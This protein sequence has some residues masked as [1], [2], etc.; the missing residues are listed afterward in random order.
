MNWI[1][2]ARENLAQ[3]MKQLR[4]R[5]R[6]KRKQ[7]QHHKQQKRVQNRRS[8]KVRDLKA[9]VKLEVSQIGRGLQQ[10]GAEK[11]KQTHL[12]QNAN[13]LASN[14]AHIYR[15]KGVRPSHDKRK[16]KGMSR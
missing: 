4:Q 2:I 15:W 12:P 16:D 13:P 9:S 5:M 1:T 3:G 7:H 8:Q 14:N 11:G 6:R 10:L